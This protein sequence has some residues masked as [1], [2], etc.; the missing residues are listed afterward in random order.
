MPAS[1]DVRSFLH[2]GENIL[3]V[4]VSYD[5]GPG[6]ISRGVRLEYQYP[7]VLPHWRRS[8]F[9]GLAQVIVQSADEAGPLK[10]TA[11]A[12]GLAPASLVI[13]SK[14]SVPGPQPRL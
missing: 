6:G 12:E 4:G 13:Q 7:P 10:L 3:A 2:A 14:A 1:F 5:G 9:N 11:T 8:V